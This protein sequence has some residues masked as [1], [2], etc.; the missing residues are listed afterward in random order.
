MKLSKIIESLPGYIKNDGEMTT[1]ISG[2]T[3][4]S[5][6][7]SDGSL[8]VALQG[9]SFDGHQF[10]EQ[11]IEQ[12]AAA[13]VYEDASSLIPSGFPSV[14]VKD[15]RVVLPRLAANFYNH[16]EDKLMLIGITGT[17]GKTSSNYFLEHLLNGSGF[18]SGRIGTT[19]A[20]FKDYSHDLIHTTPESSDLYQ[21]LNEFV[22]RGANTAT[23]EVSSHALSQ[24]R[25]DGLSFNA[26]VFSN[27][28]QDHLDYHIT[29]DE[30]LAAKRQLFLGL[31][32]D[33]VA[34]INSDDPYAGRI[35]ADS[36]A[37]T[38]TYGFDKSADYQIKNF[39]SNDRGTIIE[40]STPVGNHT[41]QTN[42]VGRF[43]IYNFVS[44]FS[45]ALE[46]GSDVE[47]LINASQD[48]PSIPGRLEKMV[49]KAP[50]N[51]FVDYA[52]TPDAMST[53]LETLAD[54]YPDKILITVFGCGG[55][56]D[57]GKRPIMGEIATRIST[58]AIITD[59]N[60]RTEKPMDIINA[61][62][63]GCQDRMNY[64]AIKD[65]TLAINTALERAEAGDIIAILGK[66]HEPYQE[67]MGE[68]KPYSDMNVI[69]EFMVK[70]GY[71][72]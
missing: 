66:G 18:E 20:A 30:Y 49:N 70:N 19:G 29:F 50:F 26:A 62:A 60:P 24:N 12:G 11:V 48:L 43:N 58:F 15:S 13:I 1:E 27:L 71:S 36:P 8:F 55:D 44:A 61:I 6:Q 22:S 9:Q 52:H 39:S 37:K 46:L 57:Q 3:H 42:T 56:R 2:L 69:N 17:N 51:V 33:A 38:R 47:S 32:D 7:V 4:D 10:I 72:A 28:T 67:I 5:R 45:T 65:R 23:L 21:L 40:L 35:V 14:Q 63:E 64:L 34:L 16:P 68:R 25:V 54:A 59:D 53:V 31:K 41:I